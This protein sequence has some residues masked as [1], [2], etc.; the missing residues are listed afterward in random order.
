MERDRFVRGLLWGLIATCAMSVFMSVAAAVHRSAAAYQVPI[1]VGHRLLGLPV[2]A[3]LVAH[4]AYGALAGG[5]FAL[6]AG[7]MTLGKGIGYGLFLWFTM[8]IT[9][10]PALGWAEFGLRIGPRQ[11]AQALLFHLVYGAALGWLGARDDVAHHARFDD[12][13]HLVVS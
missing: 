3:A 12:D 9:F 2:A 1:L 13:G 5:I 7:P 4:L 8:Q 11:A 10:V 6:L